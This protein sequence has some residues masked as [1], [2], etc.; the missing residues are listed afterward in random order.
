MSLGGWSGQRTGHI[1]GKHGNISLNEGRRLGMLAEDL[2]GIIG[3]NSKWLSGT[4]SEG[5]W[6]PT[7]L[8]Y[9]DY[10]AELT[11]PLISYL[12]SLRK[13]FGSTCSKAMTNLCTC[14]T[15]KVKIFTSSSCPFYPFDKHT[16]WTL[17]R[18][19]CGRA[20]RRI[21][22]YFNRCRQ[23]YRSRHLP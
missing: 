21:Y 5:R 10:L 2:L 3:N 7:R 14:M 18:T 9:C 20:K 22:T 16:P 1:A 19:S 11:P 8:A 23:L 4:S 12:Q 13:Q 15:P 6:W 17:F